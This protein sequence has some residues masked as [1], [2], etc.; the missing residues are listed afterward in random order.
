MKR[1]F[2]NSHACKSTDLTFDCVV[3][4]LNINN[5]G[6]AGWSNWLKRSRWFVYFLILRTFSCY[7]RPP[8]CAGSTPTLKFSK[9]F[10]VSTIYWRQEQDGKWDNFLFVI[11]RGRSRS[12]ISGEGSDVGETSCDWWH[13][14]AAMIHQMTESERGC[15]RKELQKAIIK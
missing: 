11:W 3:L 13:V 12:F 6:W 7:G 5:G 1:F 9:C 14:R 4:K 15:K 8:V 2:D 10:A